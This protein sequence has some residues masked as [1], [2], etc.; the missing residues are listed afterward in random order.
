MRDDN[1]SQREGI[2]IVVIFHLHEDEENAIHE[3]NA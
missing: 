1:T 3:H 2:V